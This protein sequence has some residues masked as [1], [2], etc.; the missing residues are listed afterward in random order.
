MSNKHLLV[1]M[2][3]ACLSMDGCSGVGNRTGL[4]K[5]PEAMGTQDF[6]LHWLHCGGLDEWRIEQ[7]AQVGVGLQGLTMLVDGAAEDLWS[8]GVRKVVFQEFL[9]E[10]GPK[11]LEFQRYSFQGTMPAGTY[12]REACSTVG[13]DYDVE[14]TC[15]S[16]CVLPGDH[17]TEV[18]IHWEKEVFDIRFFG[19][20]S[21]ADALVNAL[22]KG[23]TGTVCPGR[24]P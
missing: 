8:R 2:I 21:E 7:P 17:V 6:F 10:D 13:P 22:K 19:K 24:A 12:F 11:T 5:A 20:R 14:R 18:F 4:T 15:G 16:S 9:E 3:I 23:F 1:G